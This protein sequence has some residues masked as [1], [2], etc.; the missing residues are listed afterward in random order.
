MNVRTLVPL[1]LV[2]TAGL[3]P[4]ASA[5][6]TD[7]TCTKLGNDDLRVSSCFP[8]GKPPKI[9]ITIGASSLTL[10]VPM[11]D[12][13]RSGSAQSQAVSWRLA[14]PVTLRGQPSDRLMFSL[15]DR[16]GHKID[17]TA[18]LAADR[19]V[20]RVTW[21]LRQT[22]VATRTPLVSVAV[23]GES[24]DALTPA[25]SL[26]G[27]ILEGKN[28]FVA[29]EHPAAAVQ[30]D[31]KS[32]S[33]RTPLSADN[34]EITV[35]VGP[36]V[37]GARYS[38]FRHYVN[39]SR[40]HPQRQFLH[41]NSWYDIAYA[42]KSFNEEESRQ[43]I[44]AMTAKL[45][46]ERKAPLDGFVFD[47]GWDDKSSLWRFHRGFPNGFIPLLPDM[48]AGGTVPGTW[49]SPWGGYGEEK[50]Q[51]MVAADK[52]HFRHNDHGLLLSDPR[53]F[54]FFRRVALDMATQQ[55]V[56]Y[57]KL[58]GVGSPAGLQSDEPGL[59]TEFLAFLKLLR[60][61]RTKVPDLFVNATVGTFPSPFWL[62]Y[63]DSIWRGGEDSGQA[64]TG[65]SRERWITYRD[66]QVY[67]NVVTVAPYFPLSGLMLHGIQYAA[68]G[69][70]TKLE[71]TPDS[72]RHEVRGYFATGVNLQELYVTPRLLSNADW[73]VLAESARWARQ[74]ATLFVDSHWVGGDPGAGQVYGYASWRNAAGKGT[75][76]QA[77]VGVLSLRNPVE[78]EQTYCAD[79]ADLLDIPRAQ[80]Q[81]LA[82]LHLSEPWPEAAGRQ[83]LRAKVGEK[84][85]V[86][87]PPFEQRVYDVGL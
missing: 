2:L 9:D 64:G 67:R 30:A 84:T 18:R 22:G 27:A 17:V 33:L 65:N 71:Y 77:T 26:P 14:A 59:R 82:T 62:W 50:V 41:Y 13:S 3:P 1:L 52:M 21:R 36:L 11:V 74:R 29:A 61:L 46:T 55:H 43:A 19:T 80:R 48:A 78:R 7:G 75:S 70:P 79:I 56:R 5:H 72:F 40:G 60:S 6:E 54:D 12:G 8:T 15:V 69:Q 85:C 16:A 42:N 73:D 24:G 58:D 49:L 35:A 20:A 87:L 57:L 63:A 23:R 25:N 83:P 86:T 4:L 44:R 32:F 34:P 76:N 66:Q 45:V 47:D 31:G 10:A 81:S 51:R 53:Y 38:A 68:L 39:T 28:V 37:D